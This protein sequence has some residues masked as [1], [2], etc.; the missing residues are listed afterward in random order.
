[1]DRAVKAVEQFGLEGPVDRW[2]SVR[3]E[4]H[5]Q[6]CRQ[7]YDSARNTFVQ[8][9]GSRELDASLLMLPLVGVLPAND[10]RVVGTVE[11]IQRELMCEGFVMRYSTQSE[12][13]GLPPGEGA[14]LACTFWLADCLVLLGRR[15]EARQVFERLLNLRNDVGLLSE[16]YDPQGHRLLGNLPQAFS[17]VG[18]INTACNF[19]HDG[20]AHDRQGGRPTA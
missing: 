7:G 4:I 13:D 6:A 14:F 1:M 10:P 3:K 9:Y 20:P 11:A 18:L 16:E 8:S 2:R 5:E 17:H 19:S 12:V 15:K